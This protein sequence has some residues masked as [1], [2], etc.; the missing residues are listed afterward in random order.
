MPPAPFELLV[1]LEVAPGTRGL[2]KRST[3]RVS[4]LPAPRP[5]KR[6]KAAMNRA[7]MG[8]GPAAI[9]KLFKARV[10]ID[11]QAA[12]RVAGLVLVRGGFRLVRLGGSSLLLEAKVLLRQER[13]EA[14]AAAGFVHIRRADHNQLFRLHEPLRVHG[15]VAAADADREQLGDL[16]GHSQEARHRLEG[17]PHEI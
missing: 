10:N 8:L 14:P 2:R 5:V 6:S 1:L 7:S 4:A 13:L 3:S 17:A 11:S 16:L 12:R 9:L 15:R